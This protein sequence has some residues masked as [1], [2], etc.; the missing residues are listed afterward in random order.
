MAQGSV[1]FSPCL[2]TCPKYVALPWENLH[3]DTFSKSFAPVRIRKTF[4]TCQKCSATDLKNT[5]TSP[6]HFKHVFYLRPDKISFNFCWKI[7]GTLIKSNGICLHRYSAAWQ[8]KACSARSFLIKG[9]SQHAFLATSELKILADSNDPVHLPIRGHGYVFLIVLLFRRRQSIQNR[10]DTFYFGTNKT[11]KA[12]SEVLDSI[13]S[14]F[15]CFCTSCSWVLEC[16]VSLD[17][18]QNK[19][20]VYLLSIRKGALKNQYVQ[21]IYYIYLWREPTSFWS[22]RSSLRSCLGTTTLDFS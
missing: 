1:W 9:I 5:I 18:R 7:P 15:S 13:L 6:S 21:V 12:H 14:A 19:I 16:R 22:C 20:G 4:V 11:C 17:G 3:S 8:S 10:N 2:T